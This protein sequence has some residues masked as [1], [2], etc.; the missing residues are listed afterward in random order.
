MEFYHPNGTHVPVLLPKRSALIMTKESRYLWSH[1]ITPRKTDIISNHNGLL[2]SVPRG[3]RTSLTF[4]IIRNEPCTCV[5]S[6]QCDS[7]NRE[8]TENILEGEKAKQLEETHVLQVYNEIA[9]HFSCT[10]HKEWPKV[11]AF[12]NTLSPGSLLID[13]GCGNGKYLGKHKNLIE[14]GCDFSEKLVKICRNNGLEVLVADNL[15][16]PLRS[17]IADACISIAVLHHMA[18][19]TRRIIAMEELVRILKVNGKALIYVWAMEQK[20]VKESSNYL[21]LSRDTKVNKTDSQ[22]HQID[23][24]GTK[25]PVHINRTQFPQQDV[26]VPWHK[27]ENNKNNCTNTS[28]VYHRYYHVFVQGELEKLLSNIVNVKI[29]ES[30]YDQGN[31]CV[32]IEKIS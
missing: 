27:V 5:Y 31:W 4:R 29:L 14:I 23:F 22:R 11:A 19:E 2:K 16:L 7:Q 10:R 3:T 17:E 25:L 6:E 24:M 8:M 12:L 9:D 18:T 28:E 32:V 15:K 21:N 1:G 26:F 13:V 20:N 30:Y